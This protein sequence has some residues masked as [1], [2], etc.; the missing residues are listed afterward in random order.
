MTGYKFETLITG[1]GYLPHSRKICHIA[2][3]KAKRKREIQNDTINFG[4]TAPL[5]NVSD[6]T[7]VTDAAELPEDE[8]GNS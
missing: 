8:N 5:R 4:L 2:V 6:V 1:K 3:Q 7:L